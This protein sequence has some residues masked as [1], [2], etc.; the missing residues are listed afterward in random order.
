MILVGLGCAGQLQRPFSREGIAKRDVLHC[1][2][3]G[4]AIH[5]FISYRV[6][7]VVDGILLF[8]SN[9]QISKVVLFRTESKIHHNPLAYAKW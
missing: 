4:A 9:S 6:A 7:A 8:L 5:L 3:I 1:S 2:S